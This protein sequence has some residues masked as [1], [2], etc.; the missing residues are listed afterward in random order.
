MS[1]PKN[2]WNR[3]SKAK[4][5]K[6]GKP[7][8]PA[9]LF[10]LIA[11]AIIIMVAAPFLDEFGEPGP[12]SLG[13]EFVIVSGSENKSLEPI[14]QRFCADQRVMCTMRY[15]GSLDIGMAVEA[16]TDEIDAVWPANGIWI[17]LFD[18]ARRVKHLASISQ[19]P[20]ILGVRR[21]KA[22][23][24]GWV[25]QPVSMDDIVAAVKRGDLRFLMTSATQSN[26][27]A[28]AYLAMLS[29]VVAGDQALTMDQLLSDQTQDKV[30]S[31]LRGVARSSGSSG[32]LRD[33]FL[34][35]DAEGVTYDAM[36]NY[37]AIL[38]EANRSLRTRNSEQLYAI[39]PT[40]G[41]AMAD[42]PLGFV[43]RGQ[44]PGFE[45]FFLALQQHLLSEPVQNKLVAADRRVAL[46]RA[47]MEGTSDPSWNYDPTR[48][49]TTIRMPGPDVV[50]EAL[51][52][53]AATTILS[54][55][56]TN[57]ASI[58]SRARLVQHAVIEG[59]RAQ[60]LR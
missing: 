51:T 23:Q 59:V 39:Y 7:K 37:E 41:V 53:A 42:S 55:F 28:G 26:S 33:L 14:V 10:G 29:S 57:T 35:A 18:R 45:E 9:A 30:R 34:K 1:D 20:V 58:F 52:L 12:G 50:R 5:P 44:P 60:L 16:G 27:G 22:D 2:P 13:R 24:L 15:Q 48:F 17:D 49:V 40:D 6:G 19:S 43:D 21:S 8:W 38:A 4:G 47:S 3:P 32:W 56:C 46:G 54:L 11:V 25:D 31:L 36:W